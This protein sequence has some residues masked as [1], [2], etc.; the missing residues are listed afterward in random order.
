[1]FI[2]WKFPRSIADRVF[3]TLDLQLLIMKKP[4]EGFKSVCCNESNWKVG[5]KIQTKKFYNVYANCQILKSSW[6]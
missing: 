3:E 4:T 2:I 6:L 5:L 1:M